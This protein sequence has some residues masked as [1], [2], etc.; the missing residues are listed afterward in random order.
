MDQAALVNE[1]QELVRLLDDTALKPLAAMWV[2][3]SDTESWRLWLAPAKEI[4]DK[5]EFYRQVSEIISN[6]R[7]SLPT[8]DVGMIE[9]KNQDNQ[10]LQSLSSI[11]RSPGLGSIRMSNNRANGLLLPD[12][13]LLR[14]AI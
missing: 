1:G 9:F 11:I 2:N 4:R 6:N 7:D 5:M 3:S 14:M 12:G 10:V 8:L 13:V